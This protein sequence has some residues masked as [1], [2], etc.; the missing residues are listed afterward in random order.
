MKPYYIH[1]CDQCVYLG[2]EFH[3]K[4]LEWTH[5]TGPHPYDFYFCPSSKTLVVRYGNDG[6]DWKGCAGN[7]MNPHW[8][9]DELT[10][11]CFELA[12]KQ[13][14]IEIIFHDKKNEN[15]TKEETMEMW[16]RIKNIKIEGIK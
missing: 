8:Y 15:F 3:N 10:L 11:R 13:G 7:T 5:E 14:F 9:S 2:T 1:D 12:V 16:E 4:S 6:S